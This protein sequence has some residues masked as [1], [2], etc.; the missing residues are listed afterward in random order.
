MIK[1]LFAAAA[2]LTFSAA[3]FA[4]GVA[5]P[6]TSNVADD[7]TFNEYHGEWHL[8]DHRDDNN[9]LATGTGYINA[10]GSDKQGRP[11]GFLVV[12]LDAIEGSHGLQDVHFSRSGNGFTPWALEQITGEDGRPADIWGIPDYNLGHVDQYPVPC[13]DGCDIEIYVEPTTG[14]MTGAVTDNHTGYAYYFN[15]YAALNPY[16]GD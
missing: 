14:A 10:T 4:E 11:T 3:A 6:F 8:V 5:L 1:Q 7:G 9:I 16:H 2:A 13:V 15:S 12:M